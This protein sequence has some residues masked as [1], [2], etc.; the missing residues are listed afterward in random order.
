MVS[1]SLSVDLTDLFW[2]GADLDVHEGRCVGLHCHTPGVQSVAVTDM[3]FEVVDEEMVDLTL[4]RRRPQTPN[5][6]TQRIGDRDGWVCGICQWP[7][8]PDRWLWRELTGIRVQDDLLSPEVDHLLP[9]QRRGVDG[10]ENCQIAHAACN[11][12]KHYDPQLPVGEARRYLVQRRRDDA[13]AWETGERP[14]RWFRLEEPRRR[15]GID[16]M[17]RRRRSLL[18]VFGALG[19]EVV[20]DAASSVP[21]IEASLVLAR[22]WGMDNSRAVSLPSVVRRGDED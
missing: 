20:Y 13:W 19:E 14:L 10:D 22:R 8:D 3:F 4:P 2:G 15:T 12:H 6:R 5:R 17:S 21:E 18:R 16:E 9:K 7:V 1:C 11:R